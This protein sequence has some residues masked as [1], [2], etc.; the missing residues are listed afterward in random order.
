ML[1]YVD[2]SN[3]ALP[4]AISIWRAAPSKAKY[5][6]VTIRPFGLDEYGEMRWEVT[7]GIQRTGRTN[8]SKFWNIDQ[9]RA[10]IARHEGTNRIEGVIP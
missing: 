5:P 9:V 4:T 8:E 7:L 6:L 2:M 1:Y 3:F 10:L